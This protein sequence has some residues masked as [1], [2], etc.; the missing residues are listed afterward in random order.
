MYRYTT[1]SIIMA[2]GLGCTAKSDATPTPHETPRPSTL[3]IPA[4]GTPKAPVRTAK[5]EV[6]PSAK[7]GTPSGDDDDNW[8][9]STGKEMPTSPAAPTVDRKALEEGLAAGVAQAMKTHDKK[10][11][12]AIVDKLFAAAVGLDLKG[13][14]KANAPA[15]A[16]LAHCARL[17]Q[18]YKV[19]EVVSRLAP[20]FG[21]TSDL[22]TALVG[23]E[24]LPEAANELKLRLLKTPHDPFLLGAAAQLE[25]K[26]RDYTRCRTAARAAFDAATTGTDAE[27]RNAAALAGVNLWLSNMMLGDYKAAREAIK[28]LPDRGGI[29]DALTKL[30]LPAERN[31]LFVDV[32]ASSS[33]PLGT[34]HLAGT[35]NRAPVEMTLANGSNKDRDL[36]VSVE[37]PG[38]ASP[39]VKH[40]VVLKHKL[41]HFGI[42]PTLLTTFAS[43]SITSPRRVQ[44]DIKVSEGTD[45]V[46]EQSAALVVL[47]HDYLPTFEK[48]GA[49]TRRPMIQ[50]AGAWVTP[51]DP[52]VET[53]LSDAKKRLVGH[54]AFSGPQSATLPQVQAIYDE[55]KAR[56]VS[57]VMD[58]LINSD[59]FLGQRTRLPAQVIASTNAQCLEGTLLFAS[60]LEAL[61]LSPILVFVPGHAFVGWHSSPKDGKAPPKRLFVETTMVHTAP[62]EAAVMTA[63]KR[64]ELETSQGHFKNGM[65]QLLEVS[66][67]RARGIT[68]QVAGK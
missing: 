2:L 38:V 66:D 20:D 50:N 25:C 22:A 60:A 55:L 4:P 33:L 45:V 18:R 42:T 36:R 41:E 19:L 5:A 62:F 64:V 31:Q 52:A 7:P 6:P 10:G 58:P 1:L 30:L 28:T 49:D 29:P 63:M 13:H 34:Y 15:F 48:I 11:C 21:R 9:P 43:D 24:R 17:S 40:V 8:A 65:S 12:T 32:G 57:Y 46:Y 68:P 27:S 35:V 14:D 56:G 3:T 26:V 37:I 59:N 67:L 16:A 54:Q 61:G 51:N 47:P 39:V 53:L 23:Q 44:L